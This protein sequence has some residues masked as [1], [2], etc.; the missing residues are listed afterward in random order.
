[1]RPCY[2]R[3]SAE[4]LESKPRLTPLPSFLVGAGQAPDTGEGAS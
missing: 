4:I 2:L 1:M 3:G